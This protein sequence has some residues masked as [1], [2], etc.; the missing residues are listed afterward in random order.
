VKLKTI[1]MDKK[2]IRLFFIKK[3]VIVVN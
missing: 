1:R 2:R 3:V